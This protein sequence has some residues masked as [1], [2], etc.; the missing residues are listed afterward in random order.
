MTKPRLLT[1]AATAVAVMLPLVVKSDL[2]LTILVFS[3]LLAM[4]AVSF[5]R[6]M[7]SPSTIR[8]PGTT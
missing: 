1:V 6:A 5:N 4:L 8:S 2:T 7:P 3:F